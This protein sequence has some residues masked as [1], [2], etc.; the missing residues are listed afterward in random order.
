MRLDT[1]K[2]DMII[3]EKGM[4]LKDVYTKAGLTPVAF[5]KIRTGKTEPRL[6]TIGRIAYA[7]GVG[8]QEIIVMKGDEE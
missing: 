6:G 7:L 8:V 5:R 4:L 3:A 2:M 1:E